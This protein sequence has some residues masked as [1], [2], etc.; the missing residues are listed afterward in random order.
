MMSA[1]YRMK[2]RASRN[3]DDEA[4]FSMV[5]MVIGIFIFAM[6]IGGVVLGMSGALNV[7]RQ[8]RNRSIAANLAAQEMDTARS[9]EFTDLPLG[10]ITTT[11]SV[12]G[13][14]YTIE[15]ETE[16]VTPNAT[17]GPGQAPSGST[18]ADLSIVIRVS[19][20]GMRGVPPVHAPRCFTR[21][22]I[23]LIAVLNRR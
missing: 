9:T 19:W 18:L 8:N 22:I 21:I 15:R 7:T 5:E 20:Q 12:D 1:I 2:G 10:V 16:W 3:S 23:A 13:V 14:P 4:G 6:V 17:S 11:Q